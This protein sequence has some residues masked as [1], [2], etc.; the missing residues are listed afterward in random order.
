MNFPDG[1]KEEYYIDIDLKKKSQCTEEDKGPSGKS[2]L[3]LTSSN[4]SFEFISSRKDYCYNISYN[5]QVSASYINMGNIN[6][7]NYYSNKSNY[8]INYPWYF[9]NLNAYTIYSMEH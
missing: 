7:N 4:I 3:P 1:E 5:N 2:S 9:P 8:Y 6:N